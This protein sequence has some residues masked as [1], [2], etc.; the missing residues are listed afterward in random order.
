[1]RFVVDMWRG[2]GF[3]VS[4]CFACPYHFTN[5]PYSFICEVGLVQQARQQPQYQ[6]IQSRP[7]PR[8]NRAE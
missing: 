8:I 3:Y 5:A 7:T 6:G 4:I 1:M 2:T